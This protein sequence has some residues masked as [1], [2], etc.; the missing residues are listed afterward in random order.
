MVA[1]GAAN[2]MIAS[3]RNVFANFISVEEGLRAERAATSKS[4][5]RMIVLSGMTL[6]LIVGGFLG[7]MGVREIRTL[8][9]TYAKA[10]A[11]AESSR[12]AAEEAD[13][14]KE[15]VM[16][17][18]AHE[19]RNPINTITL[20]IYRIR[21]DPA[22]PPELARSLDTIRRAAEAVSRMVE[23]LNDSTRVRAGQLTIERQP[24]DLNEIVR[25]AIDLM[26]PAADAKQIELSA[27]A[28][29][30]GAQ[31][32]GDRDRLQQCVCNLIGNSIKFTPSGGRID[33]QISTAPSAASIQVSDNGAGI[34]PEFLPH[35]FDTF[36]RGNGTADR[37]GGLGL[38][39]SIVKAI[40]E[41]HGGSIEASSAGADR[42]AQFKV[43]LPRT[44]AESS[45]AG[46]TAGPAS[47]RNGA[48]RSDAKQSTSG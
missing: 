4:A 23:D 26:R 17:T 7:Y 21:S 30:E 41:L 25:A 2:A 14:A 10:L 46:E 12:R 11:S 35:V 18:I 40:V 37:R 9:D 3:L 47:A 39:L 48:D 38:G 28:A 16:R 5:A 33:L 6:V 22:T 32:T 34:E 1:S 20:S 24:I 43:V 15:N 8:A 42:G 36:A 27:A 45:S 29:P 31:L 19:L 13:E 44:A